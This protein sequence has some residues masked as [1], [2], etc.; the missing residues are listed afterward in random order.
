MTNKDR[1]RRFIKRSEMVLLTYWTAPGTSLSIS[2]LW[3]HSVTKFL[4]SRQLSLLTVSIPVNEIWQMTQ[5]EQKINTQLT[6]ITRK[7][8]KITQIIPVITFGIHFVVLVRVCPEKA[9]ISLLANQQIWIINLLKLQLDGL[10]LTYKCIFK[11][12]EQCKGEN[13]Q[14]CTGITSF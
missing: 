10:Q 14:K 5:Q 13:S 9:S 8:K 7:S 4:T 1:S 2:I 6:T 11:Y 12:K 3:R